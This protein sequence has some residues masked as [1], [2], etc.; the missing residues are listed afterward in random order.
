MIPCAAA[1]G[2][3]RCCRPRRPWS[4]AR[5]R[6]LLRCRRSWRGRAAPV[7]RPPP[8]SPRPWRA[9]R[10]KSRRPG[11]VLWGRRAALAPGPAPGRRLRG[12]PRGPAVPRARSRRHRCLLPRAPVPTPR[13][14]CSPSIRADSRREVNELLWVNVWN[15][16]QRAASRAG[17][18]LVCC[19]PKWRRTKLQSAARERSATC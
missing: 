12:S 13:R 3:R 7:G 18:R 2:A 6:R 10:P 9:G 1:R 11:P 16:E 5:R 17:A 8:G 19:S 15:L 4:R 14:R